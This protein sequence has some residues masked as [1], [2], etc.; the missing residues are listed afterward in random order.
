MMCGMDDVRNVSCVGSPFLQV[1]CGFR[2][3]RPKRSWSFGKN[4]L[5]R[6]QIQVPFLWVLRCPWWILRFFPSWF[7]SGMW[8]SSF[9]RAFEG[10][11]C[12][13]SFVVPLVSHFYCPVCVCYWWVLMGLI[14]L[15]AVFAPLILLLCSSKAACLRR[16]HVHEAKCVQVV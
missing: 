1:H 14:L 15:L 13:E 8:E 7:S 6:G 16:G 5:P 9:T 2:Y 4:L 10:S 11:Q 12:N 3:K